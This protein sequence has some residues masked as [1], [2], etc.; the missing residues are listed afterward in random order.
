[1]I[2]SC[3]KGGIAV[4]WRNRTA[5]PLFWSLALLQVVLGA[6]EGS[7]AM[8]ALGVSQ[9]TALVLTTNASS[10]RPRNRT[11]SLLLGLAALVTMVCAALALVTEG[12]PPG[13]PLSLGLAAVS[14][15]LAGVWRRSAHTWQALFVLLVLLGGRYGWDW[16]DPLG[17]LLL[18]NIPFTAAWGA[19]VDGFSGAAAPDRPRTTA[20]KRNSA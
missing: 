5:D 1:L 19:A 8:A 15:L 12:A 20:R 11:V 13:H 16:A 6:L 4:K 18:A 3:P 9:G 2:L 10:K 17:G 7:F 14:A